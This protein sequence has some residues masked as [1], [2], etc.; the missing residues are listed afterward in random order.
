MDRKNCGHRPSKKRFISLIYVIFLWT[1]GHLSISKRRV[2]G[3]LCV[4]VSVVL[5]F[6]L[7]ASPAFAQEFA[8]EGDLEAEEAWRPFES[9]EG[10]FGILFPGEP[11]FKQSVRDTVFGDIEE[12]HY[13]ISTEEGEFS[14]EYNDLPLLISLL[15][16]DRM[17]FRRAKDALL[18]EL[19]GKEIYFVRVKHDKLG[20]MEIGFKTKKKMGIARLYMQKRRLY[21]LVATVP[22]KGGDAANTSK[23]IDSFEL[24]KKR[25]HKPHK[26]ID[27]KQPAPK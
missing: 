18:K 22:K 26:Y 16:T 6:I 15:A 8:A 10:G 7:A 25:R 12:R 14:A 21:V 24:V 4:I 9:E 23:F 13:E 2:A 3:L 1:M 17:I 11:L 19:K 27:M 20:G 5:V